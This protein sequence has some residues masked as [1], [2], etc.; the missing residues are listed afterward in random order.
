MT[1]TPKKLWQIG[2]QYLQHI[3]SELPVAKSEVDALLKV[4]PLRMQKETYSEWLTRGE[5]MAQ[6]IPFNKIRFH[7]ITDVQLL[8]ADTHETEDAVAQIPL[9]TSNKE[10]RITI[11]ILSKNKLKLS[12]EALGSACGEYANK[13]IGISGIDSKD[14]LISQI[15][16]DNRGDGF[17]DQLDNT[18]A[19]RQVL[20]R[21]VI[22]LLD[23]EEDA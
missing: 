7:Y 18:P 13:L 2:Y 21:P 14:Q 3:Q 9:I 15:L 1:L 6:H 5:R 11:Q 8:A 4:L 16:L 10:F 17:D 12:V 23:N 19:N 22:A 20:L